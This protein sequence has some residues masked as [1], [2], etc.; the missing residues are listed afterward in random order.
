MAG[1]TRLY[2]I[3]DQGGFAGSDGVNPIETL[4]LVGEADRKWFEG[5]YCDARH[6]SMGRLK[7]MVPAEP[8]ALDALL[9]ACIIFHPDPFRACPSFPIVVEQLSDTERLDFNLWTG[10]P[11]VWPQ[12]R[13]EARSIFSQLHIWKADLV[14]LDVDG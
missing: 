11:A 7:T 14:A 5:P 1:Y 4:I 6:G 8:E 13:E 9:D 10:I 3:G 2:V 12:L